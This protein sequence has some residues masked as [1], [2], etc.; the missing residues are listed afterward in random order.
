MEACAVD[1]TLAMLIN[2]GKLQDEISKLA[3]AENL[4]LL[5]SSANLTGTGKRPMSRIY[6]QELKFC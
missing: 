1:C 5:G 4:P 3:H 6:Q 2:A